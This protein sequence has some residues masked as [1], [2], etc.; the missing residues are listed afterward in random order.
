MFDGIVMNNFYP[1][2]DYLV[3]SLKMDITG[4]RK[5]KN[6]FMPCFEQNT[7]NN[8]TQCVILAKISNSVW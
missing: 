7:E 5:K 2:L 3:S 6:N 1:W 4:T 8:T